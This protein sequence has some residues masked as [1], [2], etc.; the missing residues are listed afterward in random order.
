MKK[1]LK[2]AAALLLV[3]SLLTA[4][5]SFNVSAA[6]RGRVRVVVENKVFSKTQGAKWSGTLIDEWVELDESSTML[7]VVVKAL[8]NH[9]YS[10]TGAEDNYI[11]EINGLSAFDNGYSSG[12]MTTINDWFA[13]VGCD[14]FTVKDGTL[15]NGDEIN[16]VYSNS[17]GADIGSLW[18]NNSTRL[19]SVKFSTGELSPSFDPSVTDYTLTV[20]NAENVVAI[21]TAENKNFQVKTYKNEYT[22]TEKSTEYKK[23]TPIEIKDGDKIIV[24]CGDESWASMNQSE[25]ASVYTFTVKSAVSDK[26]N[27]TAKYLNS[28]GE[29]GVG[30]TG[31]E[32]R[33]LGLARAGKMNDDIAE[34]YYNNV[35]EY[36]TNLGSSKL[37]STKSTENSR[38]IIALSAIGKSVT[39][40]AGYNLLEP[41]ADFNFV[42]KQRVNGSAFALIALDTYKYEIPKLYDEAMQTTREKLIDE[43]LAKQLNT[44]GWT[45]FG[46]NADADLTATAI[47]ALAPYY[48]K[49]EEVKT[50]VDNALS[51]LSSM[52]KDNGAFG[53]FGSATCESTAQVLL[54]LT[55]LGIDVDTDARFIKNGNTLADALMSFSVENGFAHLS[56]GKYDQMATEQA[57]YAL[58]SYQRMK[59]GKTTLYDMSDVK[60]AKYDINGDGR[61]DI[62]DC[63]ALQKHLAALIKLNGNLDVNGDGVVSIIDV[64]F[65]QKKL[66]G[67]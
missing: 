61:F 10:Q 50:A 67:F 22:P 36:V 64:T 12:W 16:V 25:G 7:S 66:A 29:A 8:E 58:V 21:P 26:I 43:I 37:S 45:F 62:V 60:F 15:E 17:W 56:N 2:K 28:L 44:G 13:N 20:W 51:V 49:N 63:T 11:T 55:S 6:E 5:L 54:S 42:K 34:N 53:S 27:S 30:Q 41:L 31:G 9:G 24:A 23:S 48:N 40:V 59:V 4:G 18:D 1:L 32:W 35:C 52:Q 65:M 3:C 38:V 14:A 39:N 57:F 19:S 33:L 46:S 47:Q